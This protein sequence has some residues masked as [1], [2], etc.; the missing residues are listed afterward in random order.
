VLLC[1]V[2]TVI[3]AQAP[4]NWTVVPNSSLAWWQVDPHM[5]QLWATTCPAEPSWQPGEGR[6]SGWGVVTTPDPDIDKWSG[7]SDTIHVPVYPRRTAWPVC[8]EAVQGQ[9]VVSDTATGRGVHGQVTI[10]PD[11]LVTGET[12]RDAWARDAVLQTAQYP[13]IRFTVDS[14]VDVSRQVDTLRGTA[15]GVLSLHGQEKPTTAAVKAYW[16]ADGAGFRVLAKIRMPARSLVDEF[17]PGCLVRRGCVF[18][19]GVAMNIWKTMFFGADLLLR[20]KD[21]GA[22]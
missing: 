8:A 10:R 17:W 12:R 6:S 1:V 11:A 20:P 2:P 3:K 16:D 13:E 22:D 15:V 21:A 19:L 7:V 4:V 14:F 5:N 9:F 18:G